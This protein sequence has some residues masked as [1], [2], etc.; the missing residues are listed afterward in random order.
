MKAGILTFH[1]A[2]NYGAILQAFALQK[3]I[4]RIGCDSEIIDYLSKEKQENIRLFHYNSNLNFKGNITKFF[5][6]VYRS[7]KNKEFDSFMHDHMRLSKNSYSTFEEMEEMDKNAPYDV[8]IVGSDQVWNIKNNL[9]D[10]TFLLSFSK[11]NDKKCSYAASIGHAVFDDDMMSIYEEELGKFRVLSVRE[12]SSIQEFPFLKDNKAISV[13]D[14]TLLLES[15]DYEQVASP[16][17][18]KDKYAFIYTIAGDRK[19]RKYANEFCAKKGIKLIDSK[20]SKI[21]FQHSNPSDFLS[22]VKYADYVFTN[23]FHGTAFSIIMKKQFVT[24]INTA[25]SLNSRSQDLMRKTG[26]LNRDIDF[27][28]FNIEKSIDWN[29]ADE[30]KSIFQKESI[31]CLKEILKQG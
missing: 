31:N 1:R 4:N 13:L 22:F 12:E 10:K 17:I 27:Q 30:K 29:I 6:D 28:G 14:P 26:L 9:K 2:Y 24:E 20:K 15:G 16:R 7:K 23:S 18:E 8:Y 25:S 21:F 11:D 3:T 5:K 19:L